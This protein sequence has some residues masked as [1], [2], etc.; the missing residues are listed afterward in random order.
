M[1]SRTVIGFFVFGLRLFLFSFRLLN[2]ICFLFC[3]AVFVFLFL[4]ISFLSFFNDI[5]S[6]FI[7]FVLF[8]VFCCFL[9]VG[10]FFVVVCF[11]QNWRKKTIKKHHI[12]YFSIVFFS[13]FKTYQTRLPTIKSWNCSGFPVHW[14][15]LKPLILL[16]DCLIGRSGQAK[17]ENTKFLSQSPFWKYSYAPDVIILFNSALSLLSSKFVNLKSS[18][19]AAKTGQGQH[20]R[21]FFYGSLKIKNMRMCNSREYPDLVP[22]DNLCTEVIDKDKTDQ[23]LSFIPADVSK[24]SFPSLEYL[25]PIALPHPVPNIASK[26]WWQSLHTI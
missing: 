13:N 15:I 5:Y 18:S 20:I 17:S 21:S 11:L 9:S 1:I 25:F 2:N 16:T 12:W 8:R 19:R 14:V 10:V 23:L 3:L 4:F 7:F 22:F 6:F 26:L 24:E